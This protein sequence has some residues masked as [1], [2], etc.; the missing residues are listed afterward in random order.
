MREYV[1]TFQQGLPKDNVVTKGTWWDGSVSSNGASSQVLRVSVEEEAAHRLGLDLGSTVEFDIQGAK[2]SGRVTSIRKVDWG[3]L[4]TNFYFIFEPGA[5]DGAPMTY[6]ATARVGPEEE[7]PLQRAV[8]AR[9]PNVSAIN[10]RDVLDSVARVVDRIGLV[11]RFMAGLTILAGLIVLAGALAA[12]RFRRIYEAMILK[13][14]GATRGEVARSFAVE[15]ALLGGA[16]GVIGAGL[17]A[18]LA[19]G[20]VKWILDVKW[21]FQPEA[22]VWGV[23]VTTLATI[24]VGFLSTFRI[25]GQK[26]LPVL[27]RE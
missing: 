5:L 17:A 3:N 26:P 27:R 18:L 6:V 7:V 15:Y 24:V 12:T 23:V 20:V 13:A 10:I 1:L 2:V 11:I 14:V 19:W 21:L 8:V 25:L 16:A 4:S 22:I 9:F